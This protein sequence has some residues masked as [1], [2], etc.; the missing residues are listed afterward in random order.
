M[1]RPFDF[2]EIKLTAV[3]DDSSVLPRE[4]TS[5]RIAVLGD[6]S[7]RPNRGRAGASLADCRA[8]LVDR[9]NFDSVLANIA[10]ELRLPIGARAELALRFSE[11]D[12]F[13]PDRLFE[14][15]EIFR[16]L[17]E[18]RLRLKDP[19]TFAAAAEDLGVRLEPQAATKT[20]GPP[21]SA[22]AIASNLVQDRPGGLL[23]EIVERAGGGEREGRPSRAPDVLQEFVRRVTEPHLVEA[24]DPRQ[25]EL[26]RMIDRA[27]SAQMQALL[28]VPAYQSL[29][30]AWRSMFFLVRRS[31]TGSQLKLYLIDISKEDLA[32]DLISSQDLRATGAYKLFVE[33]T[34]GTPGAEPWSLIVGNYTF[35]P[36]RE[37]AE[38]LGR[39][40]KIARSARAPF[41]AAASPRLLGCASIADA[42]HPRDWRITP[43]ADA[44]AAWESLRRLPEASSIGLAMPRFL[45]RLPYGKKTDAIESFDFEEMPEG[46]SHEDYLWGNPA[47]ACALLLAQSFS[48]YGWEMRPGVH[49]QIEGLPLHVY[50]QDGESELK[51]CAEALLTDEAAERILENGLM[52]LASMKGRDA[53][54]VVKFQSVAEPFRVL[55]GRWTQ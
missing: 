16:R 10:P 34:V 44:A 18:V 32:A 12:D 31:E 54:R 49:A 7:S 21:A 42:P 23:E 25:E 26:L 53:V 17:R 43:T 3:G 29:E 39:L 28:H 51:P 47:F 9:D 35:G 2:G 46:S 5:C 11:L 20:N 15:A 55:A 13:H 22:G 8:L 40:A 37:D 38:L 6:F 45:L 19:A 36:Q 50:E 1:P 24:S 14:R 41:I 4:D 48:E 27:L 30:A 33:K 52:P